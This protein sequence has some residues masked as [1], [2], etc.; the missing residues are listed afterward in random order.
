MTTTILVTCSTGMVGSRVAAALANRP[1]VTVRAGVHRSEHVSVVPKGVNIRPIPF[2]FTSQKAV[3]AAVDGVDKAYLLTPDAEDMVD[4]AET[5]IAAARA[6]GVAHLV[7]QSSWAVTAAPEIFFGRAHRNIEDRASACGIA[8]TVLRMNN[9]MN[10]LMYL[11]PPAPDGAIY[12]PL[13]DGRTAL[14][15]ARD[16]AE[17]G[18]AA[19][20]DDSHA[21]KTYTLTGPAALTGADLADALTNATGRTIRYVDVPDDA[22]RGAMLGIGLPAWLIDAAIEHFESRRRGDAATVT[23]T[24]ERVTGHRPRSIDDFARDH[25]A[26][27]IPAVEAT[28]TNA[29]SRT[30]ST[31]PVG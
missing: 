29:A 20:T 27:W 4:Y 9:L 15:D 28:P 25:A 11:T 31:V 24:V 6:A 10:Q 21:G 16:V 1:D 2:D 5:F 3:A 18:V 26:A 23:D 12:A 8:L 13:G 7:V 19:L 14:V 17:V 30:D 22:A